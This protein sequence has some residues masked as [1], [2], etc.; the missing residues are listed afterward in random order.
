MC[1]AGLPFGDRPDT[2]Q[3][4]RHR[5]KNRTADYAEKPVLQA[6]EVDTSHGDRTVARAGGTGWYGCDFLRPGLSVYACRGGA[7]QQA[8]FG[9]E[10]AHGSCTSTQDDLHDAVGT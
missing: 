5:R 4:E 1:G 2:R 3:L 8:R 10:R 9:G 7:R 6:G